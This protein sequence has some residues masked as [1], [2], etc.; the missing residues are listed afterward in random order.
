MKLKRVWVAAIPIL[1][2]VGFFA[3]QSPQS[4]TS[5]AAAVNEESTLRLEVDLSE[6]VLSVVENGEVV[7][8]YPV[9]IGKPSYPTPKGSFSVKR[10]IWNPR[11]VPPDS[12]WAKG[13][14]PT[15]PGHP[16]NPMGK[17]KI[18]FSEPD[19][20][21]HGT[22]LVDSLG[23]AESHGCLRMHNDDVVALA[24]RVMAAGGKPVDQS[25][26]RGIINKI[27]SSKEVRLS[28]P[29]SMSV[30]A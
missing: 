20:Y 6:R 7:Q 24:Q 18:F 16:N 27:R 23:E 29:V 14:K 9:A 2:V 11:W 28:N 30:K 5:S 25:W 19:Y 13:K 3:V 4:D 22:K 8:T 1:S 21:I 15:P 17:V 10:I 12:K 26:V